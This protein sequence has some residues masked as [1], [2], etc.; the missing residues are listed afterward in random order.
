MEEDGFEK[1]GGGG[2]SRFGE[3]TYSVGNYQSLR[4]AA[5][6][7]TRQAAARLQRPCSTTS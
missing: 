7:L 3:K 6:A 2:E 5:A 1:W 4:N